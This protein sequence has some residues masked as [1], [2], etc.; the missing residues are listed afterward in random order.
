MPRY[1]EPEFLAEILEQYTVPELKK[2]AGLTPS[3]VPSRK[4]DIVSTL[5]TYLTN[6]ENLRR[7]WA[8]LDEVQQAA[9]AQLIA[10][11][12]SLRALCMVAGERHLVVPK[13]NQAAFRR[14]LRKLGYGVPQ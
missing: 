13:D 8:K 9:V 5:K 10:N 11:D 1:K 14:A 12:S 3:G 4:A 7:L 6:P 2:L